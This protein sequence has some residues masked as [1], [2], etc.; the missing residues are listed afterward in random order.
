ML[1]GYLNNH[2]L[3]NTS[4]KMIES[5]IGNSIAWKPKNIRGTLQI[6][7]LKKDNMLEQTHNSTSKSNTSQDNTMF[8]K[9]LNKIS[10]RLS[11]MVGII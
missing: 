1:R 6:L 4:F 11:N 5:R 8:L 3:S 2:I 7:K 9:K 10:D